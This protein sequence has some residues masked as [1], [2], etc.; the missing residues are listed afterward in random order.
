MNRISLAHW[1]LHRS[2][3]LG[4]C[5]GR[6]LPRIA[7]TQFGIATIELVNTLVGKPTTQSI[8]ELARQAEEFDVEIFLL[9]VDDCGDLSHRRPKLRRKAIENHRRWFDV[10]AELGCRAVRVNTGGGSPLTWRSPLQSTEVEDVLKRC[11]ESF[12]ALGEYAAPSDIRVLVENHGGL[13]ANTDAVVELVRRVGVERIGT[14][15]D[16]GNFTP[17]ADPYSAVERMLPYAGGVSAKSFDFSSDGEETTIDY[18]RML[19]LVVAARY[20]GPIGIE[21][22]GTELPEAEGIRRTRDLIEN[23]QTEEGW[24]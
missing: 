15:P 21:Y 2:I 16:F 10:A 14:L 7:R 13:S 23:I 8:R 5:R 11:A 19:R 17:T 1:S 20:D 24:T 12:A 18:R 3:A 9:M 22:E 6:D 4:E